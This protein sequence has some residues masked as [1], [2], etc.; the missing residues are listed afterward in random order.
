MNLLSFHK[1]C[2]GEDRYHVNRLGSHHVFFRSS[3]SAP[4]VLPQI[5]LAI[6]QPMYLFNLLKP[7]GTICRLVTR[8]AT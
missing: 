1:S 3:P 6:T 5:I 2:K 7:Y 8:N 4:D